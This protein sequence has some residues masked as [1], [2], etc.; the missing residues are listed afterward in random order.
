MH[1]TLVV[2]VALVLL[3][4]AGCGG[5]STLSRQELIAKAEPVCRRV[6]HVFESNRFTPQNYTH[7]APLEAKE[8]QQAADELAK[9]I[10][11]ASMA[12]DWQV[13]I[14]G[15]RRA[16]KGLQEIGNAPPPSHNKF[17]RVLGEGMNELAKGQHV[18][19]VTALRTGFKDCSKL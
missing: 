17:S 4:V 7:V 9:L 14:D 18:R 19:D 11:P 16:S 13:I 12:S 1:R 8:Y 10:P 2:P 6:N 15:F 3:A 5:S